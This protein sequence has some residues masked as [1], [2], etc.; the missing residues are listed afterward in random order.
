MN[1]DMRLKEMF[2]RL[3]HAMPDDPTLVDSVMRRIDQLPLARTQLR[4]R[5]W[6]MR[7]TIGAAVCAAAGLAVWLVPAIFLSPSVTLAQVQA[8]VA[9]QKWMHVKYD[10]GREIWTSLAAGQ[11]GGQQY[12][13]SDSRGGFNVTFL[14]WVNDVRLDYWPQQGYIRRS[15][16]IHIERAP[17]GWKWKPKTISEI[18]GFSMDIPEGEATA[19]QKEQ[20]AYVERL[21]DTI[22]GRRLIRFDQYQKNAL[23]QYQLQRQLW[24]DPETR[25]PVRASDLQQLGDRKT[26]DQ[27]Y[28]VGIYDFPDKG[29]TSIYDLGVPRDLAI[30]EP[31]AAPPKD[32][33]KVI[34]LAREAQNRFPTSYR[35]IHWPDGDRRDSRETEVIYRDGVPRRKRGPYDLS[36]VR[37]RQYHYLN[38]DAKQP[39]YHLQLPATAEQVLAW[40]KSQVPVNM[41]LSD[42][43]RTFSKHG[44]LPAPFNR[45]GSKVQ[46]PR[47][48]IHRSVFMNMQWWPTSY[49]WPVVDTSG[50]FAFLT[51]QGEALPGTV[52]IRTDAGDMRRDYY[53]DPKRDYICV[54]QVWWEKVFG[55]WAKQRQ[56][57][58]LDLKQLPGGQW[59]ATKQRLTTY[60]NPERKLGG[61]EITWNIDLALLKENEFPPDVF[62]GE[63]LLEDSKREGAVIEAY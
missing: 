18:V 60:A 38:M 41:D 6:I 27:K 63:K 25:L 44:P 28:A 12:D 24:V 26:P 58:L 14:D 21:A 51:E 29:P 57:E 32:V 7:T 34:E 17:S 19:K 31:D 53:L 59:Y 43:E 45:P 52:A 62:N 46:P 36:G 20:I 15:K 9:Q 39:K 49:Q 23:G 42:G 11:E 56:Y 3:A 30:V 37:V 10:N 35:L 55:Q 22:D 48:S 54:H 1:D 13:K 40:S 4:K 16:A 33:A 50:P 5:Y 47:L 2:R 61:Y 8:A